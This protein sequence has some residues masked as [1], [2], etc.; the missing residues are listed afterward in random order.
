[1]SHFWTL[2]W[3]GQVINLNTLIMVWAVIIPVVVLSYLSTRQLQVRPTAGQA[4]TEGVFNF[5]RSI[6]LSTAGKRGDQFL[7]YVGSVFLFIVVANLMGQLPLRLISLPH[8]ELMAATGDIN[9][10]AA[11]AV[12]TLVMY[13]F[14]GIKNKGASYFSHY[15]SPLPLLI[16]GQPLVAKILYCAC[17]WPFIFLNMFEDIT[18]PGSLMLRLFFNIF[19]GEI[20]A[21]IAMKLAPFVLPAFVIF[22]EIFVAVIQAY[23]FAMLSSVYISLMS[24]SHDDDHEHGEHAAAH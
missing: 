3:A 24:E 15:L 17:F 21:V 13:F 19:V 1:M 18:R 14:F 2:H 7:F 10:P 5:C 16:K 8:G 11:L 9:T 6:T 20:L 4:F 22:L 23:I 12:A